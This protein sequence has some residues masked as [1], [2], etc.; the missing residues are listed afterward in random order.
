LHPL[1]IPLLSIQ[2]P[3]EDH[4]W[5]RSSRHA[6]ELRDALFFRRD[7]RSEVAPLPMLPQDL[8]RPIREA[9]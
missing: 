1:L 8:H 2:H 5:E 4:E 3:T 7:E 9:F 6:S